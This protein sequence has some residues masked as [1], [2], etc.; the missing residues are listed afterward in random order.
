MTNH[1]SECGEE[2]E[3]DEDLCE[4]CMDNLASAITNTEELME[5]IL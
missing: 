1:C 5:D 2:V 4:N 3:E